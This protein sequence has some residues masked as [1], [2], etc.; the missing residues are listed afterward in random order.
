[1]QNPIEQKIAQGISPIM[2]FMSEHT[3]GEAC[4]QARE[5]IC[6]CS[7]GGK[8]HGC[9]RSPDGIRPTRTAKIDGYRY[10]L[11][12]IG[13][14]LYDEA[15]AI[16]DASGPRQVCGPYIYEWRDN[17]FGAPARLKTATQSQVNSW[18]ELAAYRDMI[19]ETWSKNNPHKCWIH[20][21]GLPS[22]LWVKIS[23]VIA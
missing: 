14:E 10:E 2:A 15:K 13:R 20:W 1:M 4:W 12:A 3:C 8:N 11:K 9:M 19:P 17:D 22:L 18:P 5:D 6:R 23:T 7:C 16:N 21:P